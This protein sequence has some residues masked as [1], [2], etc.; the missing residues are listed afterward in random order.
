MS[1]NICF[2]DDFCSCFRNVLGMSW[3]MSL[4]MTLGFV[5]GRLVEVF[6]FAL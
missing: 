2:G 1:L 5:L 6:G 4:G 3:E